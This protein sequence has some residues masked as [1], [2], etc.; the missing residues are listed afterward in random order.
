[1]NGGGGSTMARHGCRQLRSGQVAARLCLRPGREHGALAS[2]SWPVAVRQLSSTAPLA[3]RDG[4]AA[5]AMR[6]GSMGNNGADA[7]GTVIQ[8]GKKGEMQK[9]AKV[10]N[11]EALRT[12]DGLEDVGLI[13]GML[14]LRGHRAGQFTRRRLS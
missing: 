14:P 9:S 12:A 10:R 7:A 13:P 1:M 8:R 11:W 3:L 4:R 2:Q 5:V 6:S